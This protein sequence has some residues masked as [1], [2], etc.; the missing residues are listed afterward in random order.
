MYA[1]V[2]K[3]IRLIMIG[4]LA[5]RNNRKE[6]RA[7]DVGM[8]VDPIR[9]P[10]M[11]M[12]VTRVVKVDHKVRQTHRPDNAC[13]SGD[14]KTQASQINFLSNKLALRH[15]TCVPLAPSIRGLTALVLPGVIVPCCII[16][17]SLK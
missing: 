10:D 17:L 14:S 8:A 3:A 2:V 16:H 6:Y 9:R 13:R 15:Y 7:P 12:W 5:F 4:L 1:T 11:A